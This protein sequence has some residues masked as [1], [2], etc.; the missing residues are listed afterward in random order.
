MVKKVENQKN[1]RT[2]TLNS[3]S[4]VS[5]EVVMCILDF[6]VKEILLDKTILNMLSIL[7]S[8]AGIFS[9]LSQFY[10]PKEPPELHMTFYG[11]NPF[12]IKHSHQLSVKNLTDNLFIGLAALGLFIQVPLA[13]YEDDIHK[14]GFSKNQYWLVFIFIAFVIAFLV[15]S[16]A[17][18]AKRRAKK[19]WFPEII[20]SQRDAFDQAKD[21]LSHDGWRTDQLNV[22]NTISD[23]E[24]YRI[25][26]F[27]TAKKHIVQLEKLLSVK[28]QADDLKDRIE[29]IEPYFDFRTQRAFRRKL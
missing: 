21:I 15:I 10:I 18:F 25:I 24:K 14:S 2:H 8:G 11:A 16:S 3:G 7:M 29:K 13:I 12:A 9:V 6:P 20:Q 4:G 5:G 23:P 26:N 22:K 27:E 28:S 17:A 1:K 19:K